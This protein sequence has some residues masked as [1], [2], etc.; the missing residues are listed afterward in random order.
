MKLHPVKWCL[1]RCQSAGKVGSAT[2][3]WPQPSETVMNATRRSFC[4]LVAT[5]LR[6]LHA[7]ST[8]ERRCQ[9]RCMKKCQSHRQKSPKHRGIHHFIHSFNT[10][11]PGLLLPLERRRFRAKIITHFIFSS[12][13]RWVS[14]TLSGRSFSVTW[15]SS[16]QLAE[17]PPSDGLH[18]C[19]CEVEVWWNTHF[20]WQLLQHWAEHGALCDTLM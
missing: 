17:P 13:C 16:P 4:V 19:T 9:H 7:A 12:F 3:A 1:T 2:E 20:V 8:G 14:F 10:M 11:W 5:K 6:T 15:E 18:V